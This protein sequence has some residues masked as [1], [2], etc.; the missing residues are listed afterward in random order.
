MSSYTR[1][2]ASDGGY[3]IPL[4][5][6]VEQIYS[7]TEPTSNDTGINGGTFSTARWAMTYAK[8]SIGN[9]TY[10]NVY[11]SSILTAGAGVLKDMGR[12]V[13]SANRT[14]RKIQLVTSGRGSTISTFGVGGAAGAVTPVE[15]YLTGY[16]ELGFDGN[17]G[18]PVAHYG[19]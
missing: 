13:V 10:G 2:M 5:S 18:A 19:R 6:L 16:I 8:G 4:G 15:D 1:Q 12:T 11:L 17:I 14:F 3:F 7:R 9:A